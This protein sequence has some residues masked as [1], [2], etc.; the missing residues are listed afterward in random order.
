MG[1]E[2]GPATTTPPSSTPPGPGQR[3]SDCWR[4]RRRRRQSRCRWRCRRRRLRKAG[5]VAPIPG[6]PPSWLHRPPAPGAW[7]AR[8]HSAAG[9]GTAQRVGPFADPVS[10]WSPAAPADLEPRTR[11]R[12]PQTRRTHAPAR[13]GRA[14]GSDGTPLEAGAR[15][16]PRTS[17]R[18]PFSPPFSAHPSSPPPHLCEVK[19]PSAVP[20]HVKPFCQLLRPA[21]L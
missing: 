12:L 6:S 11:I 5:P 13:R 8:R 17:A 21:F 19:R 10:G 16:S 14:G 3:H 15:G 18:A 1:P 20:A 4:R 7:P 2:L 9:T